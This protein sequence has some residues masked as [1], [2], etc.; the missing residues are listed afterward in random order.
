MQVKSHL[1]LLTTDAVVAAFHSVETS[2]VKELDE[3]GAKTLVVSRTIRSRW[4]TCWFVPR[5]SARCHTAKQR[6]TS[7]HEAGETAGTNNSTSVSSTDTQHC[8][9]LRDSTEVGSLMPTTGRRAEMHLTRGRAPTSRSV[10]DVPYL[11]CTRT[12]ITSSRRNG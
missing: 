8:G 5:A 1:C 12:R 3:H 10:L 2:A 9:A 6:K 4:L 11:Y 7:S